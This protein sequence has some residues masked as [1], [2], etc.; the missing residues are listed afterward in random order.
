MQISG[1]KSFQQEGDVQRS[2][3]K[4]ILGMSQEQG[5]K[6]CGE[7]GMSEVDSGMKWDHWESQGAD[8]VAQEKG[9]W[10]LF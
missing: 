9:F 1:N 3:G 7:S 6:A 8:F 2:R 5:E 10:I 4:T